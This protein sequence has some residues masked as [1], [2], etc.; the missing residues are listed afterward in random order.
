M[1]EQEYTVIV[2]GDVKSGFWTQ[3]P[4]L[5]GCGSQGETVEEAVEMT[6]EAIQSYLGSLIKH[7]EPVPEDASVVVKVTVAA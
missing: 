3:V 1:K 5:P 2:K 6:K 4:A 7:G